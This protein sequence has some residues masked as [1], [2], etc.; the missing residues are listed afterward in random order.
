MVII[1][2]SSALPN[3]NFSQQD[4]F[5][6]KVIN[7]SPAQTHEISLPENAG[8]DNSTSTS[9]NIGNFNIINGKVY[10]PAMLIVLS[11]V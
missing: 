2:F 8:D 6:Q 7:T 10:L 5:M 9:T 3:S 1:Q 11:L 4:Q